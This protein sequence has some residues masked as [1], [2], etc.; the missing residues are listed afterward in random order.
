MRAH[1]KC[2]Y[3]GNDMRVCPKCSAPIGATDINTREGVGVCSTCGEIFRLA[4]L[5]IEPEA[6]IDATRPPAGA[7]FRTEGEVTKFGATTRSWFALFLIPFSLVWIGGVA[8]FT[9]FAIVSAITG[10]GPALFLLVFM[11]PF[12]IGAAFLAA[13]LA[14]F[15]AGKVEVTIHGLDAEVFTGV[16][17][18]GRRKKFNL[19]E[20]N[21]VVEAQSNY[22]TPVSGYGTGIAAEGSRRVVFGTMLSNERRYYVAG[23]LRAI[24]EGRGKS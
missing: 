2:R 14:M 3:T 22:R 24:I 18:I 16:G 21:R 12:W 5:F 4:A 17:S 13:N 6:K 19:S 11:L 10:G 8:S 15:T 20:V 23:V 1:A 7:W 9:A